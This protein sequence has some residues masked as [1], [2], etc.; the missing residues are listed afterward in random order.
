[1]SLD[2]IYLTIK[3]M[4]TVIFPVQFTIL[5]SYNLINKIVTILV[6]F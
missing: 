2:K 6:G 3:E 5:G 4:H 1:M